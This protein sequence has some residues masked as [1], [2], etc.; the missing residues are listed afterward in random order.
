M[1][2]VKNGSSLG[3]ARMCGD[4]AGDCDHGEGGACSYS[5]YFG[6]GG[7]GDSSSYRDSKL[8][9]CLDLSAVRDLRDVLR[10]VL[11][12]PS[13]VES[14]AVDSDLAFLGLFLDEVE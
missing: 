11:A 10:G 1:A 7:C 6:V 14:C 8:D 4:G 2:S 9:G 13:R 5:S 12:L 3:S